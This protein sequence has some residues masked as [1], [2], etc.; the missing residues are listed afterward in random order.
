MTIFID[1]RQLEMKFNHFKWLNSV[2]TKTGEM[3]LSVEQSWAGLDIS[4]VK[5]NYNTEAHELAQKGRS[6]KFAK[7][8]WAPE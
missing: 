6:G 5:R 1:S 8:Y 4:F 7:T 3:M 2:Q